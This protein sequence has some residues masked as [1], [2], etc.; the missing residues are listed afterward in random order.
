MSATGPRARDAVCLRL[1]CEADV[2]PA[3]RQTGSNGAAFT[4]TWGSVCRIDQQLGA[5]LDTRAIWMAAR[6]GR[7][8]A[9]SS[10]DRDVRAPAAA[11]RRSS[12][13]APGEEEQAKPDEARRPSKLAITFEK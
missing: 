1:E 12:A 11:A 10:A 4:H 7:V 9:C 8:E 3:D 13:P 6:R 5:G 2:T